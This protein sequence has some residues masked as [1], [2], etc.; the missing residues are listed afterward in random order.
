MGRSSRKSAAPGPENRS[1]GAG[2]GFAGATVA[3]VFCAAAAVVFG[4]AGVGG[5][6]LS[7]TGCV[8]IA[9]STRCGIAGAEFRRVGAAAREL[10]NAIREHWRG[11]NSG[12]R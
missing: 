9:G 8:A 1:A 7:N 10:A 3:V 4:T 2:G 5:S 11:R 6:R 12:N